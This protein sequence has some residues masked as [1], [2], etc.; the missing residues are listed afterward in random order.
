MPDCSRP[1]CTNR[2]RLQIGFMIGAKGLFGIASPARVA[3]N[4]GVCER[5]SRSQIQPGPLTAGEVLVNEIRDAVRREFIARNRLEPDLDG[6]VLL[7]A[8]MTV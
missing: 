7:F 8:P 3:L 5:H 2:A 4:M 6:A 1:N